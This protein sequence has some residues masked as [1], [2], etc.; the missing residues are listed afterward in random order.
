MRNINIHD[1]R[2][3]DENYYTS[4]ITNTSSLYTL[5]QKDYEI[6]YNNVQTQNLISQSLHEFSTKLMSA[7][8]VSFDMELSKQ[9]STAELLEMKSIIEN[10]KG[11][12]IRNYK[13]LVHFFDLFNCIVYSK[14]DF[15]SL[16]PVSL[17]RLVNK[18][19]IYHMITS[20]L[21]FII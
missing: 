3:N 10:E 6:F 4:S 14:E 13:E 21:T 5:D 17:E 18:R 20:R 12:Q 15:Y 7:A 1:M 8:M 2:N 16:D 11:V 9:Y 19:K